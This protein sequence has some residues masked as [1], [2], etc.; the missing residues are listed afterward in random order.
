MDRTQ[1]LLPSYP[2]VNDVDHVFSV[3]VLGEV[4]LESL[5]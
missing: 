2:I 3:V 5:V 4:H 1:G